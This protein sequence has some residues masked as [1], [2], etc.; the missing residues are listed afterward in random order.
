LQRVLVL[1][2]KIHN[3]FD[4]GMGDIPWKNPAHPNALSMHFEHDLCSRSRSMAKNF[5]RTWT[6]NSI[7][8]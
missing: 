8:V 5:C 6:T 7:G 4:L 3:L 2:R 1:A